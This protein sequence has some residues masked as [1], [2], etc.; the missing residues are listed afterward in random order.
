VLVVGGAEA[1]DAEALFALHYQPLQRYLVRFTGDPELA[2]DV[3]Q[4]AFVRLLER[5]PRAETARAWLYRVATNLARDHARN[6]SRRQV[7]GMHG[8]AQLAHADPPADPDSGI[9]AEASRRLLAEAMEA[10][11]PKERMALLMREEGFAHREIADAIGTT[12]GSVGTLLA[13]AIRKAADRLGH[14]Q[15]KA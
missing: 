1:L 5:P 4:E 13:R 9:E 8:R 2:A 12:T 7:L 11:S 15:E 3:A 6:S 14:T 10:L